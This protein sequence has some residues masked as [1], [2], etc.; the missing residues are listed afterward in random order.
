[1]QL[2]PVALKYLASFASMLSA[3]NFMLT[4]KRLTRFS[5]GGG[6]D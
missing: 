5:F 2:Y 1:M 3:I 6:R 4:T